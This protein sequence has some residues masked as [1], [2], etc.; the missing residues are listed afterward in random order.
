MATTRKK[1]DSLKLKRVCERCGYARRMPGSACDAHAVIYVPR[2]SQ[3]ETPMTCPTATL[4]LIRNPHV[5]GPFAP[6][7]LGSAG[8]YSWLVVGQFNRWAF[9]ELRTDYETAR[10][11]A[12][13]LNAAEPVRETR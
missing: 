11:L 8:D 7:R 6:W 13:E 5:V 2:K 12:D 9:E 3:Q 1:M 10:R 4:N